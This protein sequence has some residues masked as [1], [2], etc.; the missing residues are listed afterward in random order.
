MKSILLG[1]VMCTTLTAL[2]DN[3]ELCKSDIQRFSISSQKKEQ[4]CENIGNLYP[5]FKRCVFSS[6]A[7]F[8]RTEEAV[9]KASESDLKGIFRACSGGRVQ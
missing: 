9:L 7:T 4:I 1:L 3:Y 2:A 8:G 6:A 5:D